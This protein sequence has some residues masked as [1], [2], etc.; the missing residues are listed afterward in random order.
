VADSG[1]NDNADEPLA[2][3][4][5]QGKTVAAAAKAANVSE[6]T[7]YRRL[8]DPAFRR[9]VRDLRGEMV[10]QAVGRLTAL[11]GKALDELERLLGA[12]DVKEVA[13]QTG[14]QQAQP[15]P[16][17][18]WRGWQRVGG[19]PWVARRAAGGAADRAGRRDILRGRIV[20]K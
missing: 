5:A 4:L 14:Q 20:A 13:V 8:A 15:A 9:L 2:L 6:R 17:P 19:G 1:R 7:A 16:A 3:G 12:G 10:S 18:R 11:S